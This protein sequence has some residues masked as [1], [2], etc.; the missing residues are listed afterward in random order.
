[1]C[2]VRTVLLAMIGFMPTE[3]VGAIG[4][5]DCLPE[6]RKRLAR[7][8]RE[9]TCSQCGVPNRS[10]LPPM[11]GDGNSQEK[12]MAEA[13]D[14]VTQMAFKVC[15]C[16]RCMC[17]ACFHL[18]CCFVDFQQ[19]AVLCIDSIYCITF[20]W[21]FLLIAYLPSYREREGGVL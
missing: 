4:S 16:V 6:E 21:D 11:T 3:G 14:I 8:S 12:A 18:E 10:I 7:H 13:A 5:L 1:M 19:Y 2:T 15:V 17:V 9:W 20:Q